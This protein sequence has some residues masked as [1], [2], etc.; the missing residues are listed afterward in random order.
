MILRNPCTDS[1]ILL[2]TL[3][4][5]AILTED[6]AKILTLSLPFVLIAK[7]RNRPSHDNKRSPV[8]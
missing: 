4:L 2:I 7:V 5:S 6:I 8:Q 1:H 3:L